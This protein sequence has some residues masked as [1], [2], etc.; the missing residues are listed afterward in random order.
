VYDSV[1]LRD[2]II[3][4]NTG[5]RPSLPSEGRTVRQELTEPSLR[6]GGVPGEGSLYLTS[7]SLVNSESWVGFR[8]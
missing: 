3:E 6:R 7:A 4:P 2:S 5:A 1:W 8:V